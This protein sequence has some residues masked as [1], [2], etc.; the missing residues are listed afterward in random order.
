MEASLPRVVGSRAGASSGRV[1][2]LVLWVLWDVG[3]KKRDLVTDWVF[4]WAP[5]QSNSPV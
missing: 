2:P 5:G 3:F 1:P 4:S